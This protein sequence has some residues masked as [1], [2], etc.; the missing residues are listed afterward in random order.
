MSLASA[1]RHIRSSPSYHD[2][3]DLP[4]FARSIYLPYL[5]GGGKISLISGQSRH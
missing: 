1:S 4:G 2:D 5:E 3:A